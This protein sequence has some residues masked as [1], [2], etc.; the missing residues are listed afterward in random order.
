[1]VKSAA[2]AGS[3]SE[4]DRSFYR[5]STRIALAAEPIEPSQLERVKAGVIGRVDPPVPEA[6]PLLVAWLD[7]IE[8]KL[9]QLLGHEGIAE[10]PLLG[11]RDQ[12][13]IELSGSG[14]SFPSELS[15]EIGQLL[16]LQFELPE[17]PV[18]L[19]RCVGRIAQVLP[20]RDGGEATIGVAFETIRALDRDAVVHYT[21]GVQRQ[22]I[23]AEPRS[24]K[25]RTG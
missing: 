5:V 1:M 21:V 20:G 13:T 9:D 25:S 16:L 15:L 18:R 17:V 7:R 2:G 11:E 23:R 6:D 22:Q 24:G 14:L 12:K 4:M 19:V 3:D 10:R 8:R